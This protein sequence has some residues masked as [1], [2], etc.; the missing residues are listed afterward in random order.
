MKDVWGA[1]FERESKEKLLSF[2][3]TRGN[4]PFS[5]KT[6]NTVT[7]WI[8][9]KDFKILEAGSGSGRACI[10][11][12]EKFPKSK[13]IGVDLSEKA[14]KIAKKGV[15]LRG[16]KNVKFEKADIFKMPFKDDEF[17]VVFNVGVIEHFENYADVV[18]EMKRV[19]KK[20]GKMIIA[21]PNKYNLIH[22]IYNLFDQKILKTRKY[23]FE[24]VFSVKEL[25]KVFYDLV[26]NN[27]EQDGYNPFY[28]LS[29]L[30]TSNNIL[31][32]LSQKILK[33]IAIIC[34]YIFTIPLDIFSN[35]RFSKYFGW[36]IVIKGEK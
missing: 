36:E 21:V 11:L 23:G 30:T 19:V 2:T 7:K 31:L 3:S 33:I 34:E 4:L 22:F 28:R 17:D 1:K 14:L 29:K 5:K 27:I 13:V 26:F 6:Y 16:L 32:K 18:A 8:D 12:A 9:K 15:E 25:K 35:H 20:N 10:F 24:M